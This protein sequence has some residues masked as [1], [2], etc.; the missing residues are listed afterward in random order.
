LR[1]RQW[2]VD[3]RGSKTQ[4]EIAKEAKIARSY[5][6]QIEMGARNPSV[7]MAKKIAAALGFEWTI[8]FE[9]T[10]CATQ[11]SREAI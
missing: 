11:P 7:T 1:K 8:F 4:E 9:E 2:L 6:A 5:Y 10:G 3:I